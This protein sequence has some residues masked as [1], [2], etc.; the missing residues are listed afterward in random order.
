MS[1][2]L[3]IMDLVEEV[4][5]RSS[6]WIKTKSEEHAFFYWQD[7]YAA[8]SVSPLQAPRVVRYIE[9]QKAHHNGM[10]FQDECRMFFKRYGMEWDERYVWD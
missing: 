3:A 9:N 4:K 10:S 1:R 6:K 8:F 7:G 2:K 5:K